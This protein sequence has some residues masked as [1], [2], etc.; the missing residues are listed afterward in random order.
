[1]WGRG[2]EPPTAGAQRSAGPRRTVS[3][4]GAQANGLAVASASLETLTLAHLQATPIPFRFPSCPRGAVRSEDT[5]PPASWAASRPTSPG[6]GWERVL[7]A[8]AL[9]VNSSLNA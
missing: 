4:R 5:G 8:N 7:N 9:A 3:K 1:M 2:R 6:V